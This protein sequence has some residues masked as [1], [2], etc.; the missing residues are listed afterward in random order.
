MSYVFPPVPQVSVAVAGSPARFP[1]ARL[2][3][4]GRNYEA[5]AREMGATTREAPFFFM[6]PASSLVADGAAIA[7]P[8][9]T[10]DLHHEIELVVAIGTGGANIP[11]DQASRHIFGYAVG[12]DLTRRDLQAE[13]KAMGR[14]WEIGK[15]FDGAAPISAI[16]PKA[17]VASVSDARIT[18][19]VNGQP[20]QDGNLRDL[21]WSVDE[22]IAELSTYF[23]LQPGDLIYTGTPAG[24][25]A[26]RP[27]DRLDGAVE[28]VG[29][30][31]VSIV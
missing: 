8:P 19:A 6:K 30:L 26:V 25:A 1:V 17:D 24:V 29:T 15:V 12:L 4:V 11:L 14:S 3:C 13:M 9:R 23:T 18:L 21:I 5:H 22:V 16:R 7:Y 20:R 2:F 27:G 10:H 31:T 28:G